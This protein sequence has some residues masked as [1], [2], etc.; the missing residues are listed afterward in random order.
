MRF[1]LE[2]LD[3]GLWREMYQSREEGCCEG[4]GHG[5]EGRHCRIVVMIGVVD[6]ESICFS[7]ASGKVYMLC[8]PV[9]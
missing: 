5:F 9:L 1:V 8:K 4:R 6:G 2:Y 7:R 3:D